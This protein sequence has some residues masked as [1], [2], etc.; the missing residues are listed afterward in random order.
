MEGFPFAKTLPEIGDM[1]QRITAAVHE[2]AVIRVTE[3]C[4]I[5]ASQVIIQT[6]RE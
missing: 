5:P 1:A 4:Q 3:K 2:H 6:A